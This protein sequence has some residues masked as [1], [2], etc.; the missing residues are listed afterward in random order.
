MSSNVKLAPPQQIQSLVLC[1]PTG[2]STLTSTKAPDFPQSLPFNPGV[3]NLLDTLAGRRS[4]TSSRGDEADDATH[5]RSIFTAREE[6]QA[7]VRIPPSSVVRALRSGVTGVTCSF[8]GRW[9]SCK[10]ELDRHVRI[11][12]GEKPYRCHLCPYSASVKCNL[13]THIKA[14]HMDTVQD[15]FF[16]TS[17]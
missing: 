5:A 8:C 9:A 1:K 11:H 10:A 17:P 2:Q 16:S 4:P 14:K 3:R 7:S 15:S 12:T 6:L 13:R